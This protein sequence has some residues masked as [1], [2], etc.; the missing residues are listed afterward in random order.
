MSSP[1]V[2]IALYIAPS[3]GAAM[4]AVDEVTA[5][6]ARGLE[7]DRYFNLTGTYSNHPG[8]GRH[9]TL[10][11]CEAIEALARD[12]SIEIDPGSARRNIVTHGV[13]LNHLV[14]RDFRVGMVVMH[15]TRLCEPC[16]HLER[17]TFKGVMPGLIH[18]GGLRAEIIVGG[19]INV[20]VSISVE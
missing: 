20:G 14:G 15:G 12:Y 19:K 1:G 10:I 13:A 2:A 17:F 3:A 7:G 11:E 5:V 9:V 6:A 18:R 8:D 4:H 16:I